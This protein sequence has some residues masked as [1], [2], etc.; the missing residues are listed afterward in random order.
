MQ[1]YGFSIQDHETRLN[2]VQM[3]RSGNQMALYYT[4]KKLIL[5]HYLQTLKGRVY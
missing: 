3:H 5:Q 1:P 2:K 4:T